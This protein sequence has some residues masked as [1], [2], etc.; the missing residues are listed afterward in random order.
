MLAISINLRFLH[1]INRAKCVMNM[2]IAIRHLQLITVVILVLAVSSCGKVDE[3]PDIQACFEQYKSAILDKDGPTA[4][5]LVTQSTINLYGEYR[6]LA[7]F[8]DKQE[9]AA[10]PISDRLSVAM[11]RHMM[12]MNYLEQ[13]T[14]QQL[15]MYGV[16]EGWVGSSEFSY[17]TMGELQIEDNRATCSALI[18]GTKSP[19]S[20]SFEKTDTGW[21]MNL[22][23]L[24]ASVNSTLRQVAVMQ[25]ISEDQLIINALEELSGKKVNPKIWEKPKR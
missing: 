4:S 24:M 25:G 18:N 5:T 22:I 14:A 10:R 9:I 1:T 2:Q 11:L 8:S 6:M 19:E 12:D 20:L 21:K 7:L 15:F 3:T 13:L 17:I 23:P 16:S